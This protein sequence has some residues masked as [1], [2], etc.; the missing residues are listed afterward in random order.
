MIGNVG[1]E[2]LTARGDRAL[3]PPHTKDM[4]EVLAL[5]T[6]ALLVW[7]GWN[8]SYRDHLANVLSGIAPD[9]AKQVATQHVTKQV[10]AEDVV[11]VAAPKR[12]NNWMWKR[13]KLD[14]PHQKNPYDAR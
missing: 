7:I 9:A 10:A 4:R 8:Q 6:F 1:N 5:I 12:D 11:T 3:T 2:G 14:N 13:S